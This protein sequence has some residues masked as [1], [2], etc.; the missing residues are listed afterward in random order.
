MSG[1]NG[2]NGLNGHSAAASPQAALK[3][4]STTSTFTSTTTPSLSSTTTAVASAVASGSTP[5]PSSYSYTSSPNLI[6]LS[7]AKPIPP[8]TVSKYQTSST[9]ST[10]SYRLSSLDRLAQRQQQFEIGSG[11]DIGLGSAP[12]ATPPPIP[13]SVPG[14]GIPA[15]NG[16]W[17]NTSSAVS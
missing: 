15:T 3:L 11:A 12:S 2:V 16:S 7:G 4:R 17:E 5:S 9:S 13:S 10:K 6:K 8:P 1:L 14:S